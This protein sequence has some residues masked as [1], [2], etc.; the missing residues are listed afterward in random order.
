[1]PVLR[2]STDADLRAIYDYNVRHGTGSF[3]EVPPSQDELARR[4]ADIL[5]KGL[6]YL[7]ATDGDAVIGYAYVTL[8]RPRSSYRFT[9][10]D[11]IY[12]AP[13]AMGKGVGTAL[14][15]ELLAQ[16]ERLGYRQ[17]IANIGDSQNH[18]SIKLHAKAGFRHAGKLHSVGF[19]FGRWLDTVFMQKDLGP[20]DT[21]L[22]TERIR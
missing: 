1:M 3:E 14:L 4:R 20:G 7:V 9:L 5:E 22:P 2:A 8:Y 18:A 15:A 21:S 11:S 19:K 16:S 17:M 12:L 6:P 13:E 10:E